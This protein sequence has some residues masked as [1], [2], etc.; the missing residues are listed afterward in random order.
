MRIRIKNLTMKYKQQQKSSDPQT[1]KKTSIML[2]RLVTNYR[3]SILIIG[4]EPTVKIPAH[5]SSK[6]SR[7]SFLFLFFIIIS[8]LYVIAVFSLPVQFGK[9]KILAP[10]DDAYCDS[11]TPVA[12]L[13]QE[14]IVE[15]GF[16]LVRSRLMHLTTDTAQQFYAE[17]R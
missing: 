11:V 9:L 17:H 2:I 1:L 16:I 10:E 13:V 5:F 12:C 7:I 4:V 6:N 14:R 15:E 3:Y 8:A